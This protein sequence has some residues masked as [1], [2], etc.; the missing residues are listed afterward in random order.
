MQGISLLDEHLSVS[1]NGKK[2]K[3]IPATGSEGP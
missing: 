1:Q 3:A 2:C